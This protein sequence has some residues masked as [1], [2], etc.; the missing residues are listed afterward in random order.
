MEN[1]NNNSRKTNPF[2]LSEQVKK[3]L[4]AKG[5]T[6]I[7]NYSDYKHFKDKCKGAFNK[8]VDIAKMFIEEADPQ[9]NDF[10]N[11]II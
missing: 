10:S 7:F 3:E 11:Y 1:N 5:Y 4:R 2:L 9:K 8:A 6:S